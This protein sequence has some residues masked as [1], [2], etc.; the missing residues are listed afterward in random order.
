MKT[1]SK[2]SDDGSDCQACPLGD[3]LER[4]AF[5]RDTVTQVLLALGA[6][7]TFSGRA[8]ALSLAYATGAGSR[9]DKTYAIPATDGVVIDKEESVIIARFDDCAYAFSLACP[10][11]NTALRWD[12]AGRRFQCPKHK[13]RYQ[14][15]GVFIEGRATRGMDR[16]AVRSEG[17]LL[18][19][20]L[21]ALYRED[22]HPT[23]WAAAFVSLSTAENQHAL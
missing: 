21:D 9:T 19:V 20:N 2:R 23:E 8:S 7:A 14:P 1:P 4:R 22:K 17:G 10:H 15:S 11:Q 16:F 5:L 3:V 13:S 18:S 12:A 6:M